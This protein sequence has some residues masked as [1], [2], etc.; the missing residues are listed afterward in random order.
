MRM[1]F[2]EHV[3]EVWQW[4]LQLLR[5]HAAYVRISANA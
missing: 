4:A 5:A 2:S 1:R 3:Y